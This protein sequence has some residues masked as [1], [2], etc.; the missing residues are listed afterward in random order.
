M[1]KKIH[2]SYDKKSLVEIINNFNLDIDVSKTR[3]SICKDII[4]YIDE[5]ALH[6]LYKQNTQ[7][8]ITF[9]K[10]KEI[11]SVARQCSA[12]ALSGDKKEIYDNDEEY[13]RYIEYLLK[14][15]DIPSVRKA[16]ERCNLYKG[17]EY[18]PVI[19]PQTQRLIDRKKE[20]KKLSKPQF[21]VKIGKFYIDL[22]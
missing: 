7:K 12:Y 19:S 20:L 13:F 14:Y 3:H 2:H 8:R 16:I 21:N 18:K 4:P 6:Y 22:S 10:R 1:P 17:T 11:I 15:G 5:Y 9:D